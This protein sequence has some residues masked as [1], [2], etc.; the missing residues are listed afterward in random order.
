MYS[1]IFCTTMGE[2]KFHQDLR[3]ITSS[4]RIVQKGLN[5]ICIYWVGQ[6][7]LCYKLWCVGKYSL[8]LVGVMVTGLHFH[9]NWWNWMIIIY[10]PETITIPGTNV[11]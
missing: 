8:F 10:I 4:S 2:V 6:N 3:Y 7:G 5:T 11:G 9:Y 1:V